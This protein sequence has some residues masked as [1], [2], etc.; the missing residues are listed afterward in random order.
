MWKE[1]KVDKAL[2]LHRL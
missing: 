1:Y 2:A